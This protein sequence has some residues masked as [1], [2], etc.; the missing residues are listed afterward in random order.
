MIPDRY[1]VSSAGRRRLTGTFQKRSTRLGMSDGAGL[2][3]G[4]VF[5]AVGTYII[6]IGTKTV[7][8]NP[9]SVHAPYWVLTVAGASFALGGIMVWGMTWKQ[10]AAERRRVE[11]MRRHPDEPALAD[12]P[13]HPEGFTVSEW[14]GAAKGFAGA[15]GLT[16]FLS[17]FNWWAWGSGEGPWMVKGLT[18]LFDLIVLALWWVAV[19]QL[20]RAL[21][22]GH[23]RV[24]FTTFPCH[25]DNPV[26]LRWQPGGGI[27]RINRGTFTLRCVEEWMEGTGYGKNRQVTVVHE[28]LWSAQGLLEQ[29]RTLQPREAVELRYELP[30]DARTTHLDAEK[31]LFWELEVKL[32]LPGLNFNETYLVPVYGKA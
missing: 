15:L 23:S 31:P 19:R 1:E 18:G 32:E 28:E 25:P 8:V 14:P 26:V 20:A 6:L 27:S 21:K 13:W 22:F 17:M 4:G 5:V 2:A 3:F 10:F 7:A 29:P 12:Y 24:E 9:A 11:A 30:P 16:V